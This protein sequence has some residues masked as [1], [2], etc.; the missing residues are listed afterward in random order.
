MSLIRKRIIRRTRRLINII[1]QLGI[2]PVT[3]LLICGYVTS[4][5]VGFLVELTNI[6]DEGHESQHVRVNNILI[7]TCTESVNVNYGG[8]FTF[9]ACMTH[10]VIHLS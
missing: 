5:V 1:T 3:K 4:V 2:S 6:I 9:S 8:I 10:G 7:K